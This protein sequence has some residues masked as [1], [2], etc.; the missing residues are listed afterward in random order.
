M[1]KFAR[2]INIEKERATDFD[3]LRRKIEL[4][5]KEEMAKKERG[6]FFD[7]HFEDIDPKE[8]SEES[9]NI[10]S[11]FLDKTLTRGE[12]SDYKVSGGINDSQVNFKAYLGNK[13]QRREN[14]EWF[15][16]DEFELWKKS[17]EKRNQQ[18]E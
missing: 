7:I 5:K 9:L 11:R 13:L 1:E 2:H 17:A 15:D 10:F 14:L 6:E 4:I 12:F 8:L 18:E 16:P 3:E